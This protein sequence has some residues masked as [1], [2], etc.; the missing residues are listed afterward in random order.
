MIREATP[1][2]AGAIAGVHVRC[3]QAAYQ[4]LLPGD[5]LASLSVAQRT[6][7]WRR[8]LDSGSTTWVSDRSSAAGTPDAAAVVGFVSVGPARGEPEGVGELY[9]IYLEPT[10]IGQGLGL[11][12]MAH[13]IEHLQASGFQQA[14][15]WVLE[16]NTRAREFYEAAGWAADGA[17]KQESIGGAEVLELRYRTQLAT[18]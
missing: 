16:S 2:D 9:A 18:T 14:I 6:A 13:A 10:H 17:T 4:G 12:L 11:A 7:R 8:L 15:L 5:Y 3:W 1:A